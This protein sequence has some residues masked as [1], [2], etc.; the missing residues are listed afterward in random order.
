[1]RF[2]HKKTKIIAVDR[3]LEAKIADIDSKLDMIAGKLIELEPII[4]RIHN[5]VFRVNATIEGDHADIWSIIG[6]K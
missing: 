1:V 5:K 6:K 4:K 2:W 3:T